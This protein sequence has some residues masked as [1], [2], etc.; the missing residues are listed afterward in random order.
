VLEP[1]GVRH[2]T[3][4]TAAEKLAGADVEGAPARVV[5]W[6]TGAFHPLAGPAGSHLAMGRGGS[7]ATA[8]AGK[9]V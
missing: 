8:S 3:A 6:S 2:L 7:E 4:R 5:L 9:A 1:P